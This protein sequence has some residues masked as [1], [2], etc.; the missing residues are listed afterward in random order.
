[1][2]EYDVDKNGKLDEDEF[3]Q[4]ALTLFYEP[5]KPEESLVYNVAYGMFLTIVGYPAAAYGAR[6]AASAVPIPFFSFAVQSIPV[7]VLAGMIGVAVPSFRS[8]AMYKSYNDLYSPIMNQ[9]SSTPS[10]Q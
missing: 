10:T 8:G 1:M 4:V 6:F 9:G 7:A 3:F 2:S 5:E